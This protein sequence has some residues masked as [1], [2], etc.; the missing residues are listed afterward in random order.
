MT[1]YY[2]FGNFEKEITPSGTRELYYVNTPSGTVAVS[3]VQSGTASLYYISTDALG[4]FDVITSSAGVVVERNSFDPWGR[5]RNYS[6]WTYSNVNTSLFTGRGFTGHEHLLD[7]DLI[8]MNGRIYDPVMALF[9]SPDNFLQAPERCIGFDR[10]S[11]CFNNPLKF[12][13][14]SGNFAF[15]SFL[16][17]NALM[18]TMQWL[19]N[20]LNLGM[21]P[22]EA[23]KNTP[24]T[25]SYSG[26]FTYEERVKSDYSAYYKYS[27]SSSSS[28]SDNSYEA[29]NFLYSGLPYDLN[30]GDCCSFHSQ[31]DEELYEIEFHVYQ[32]LAMQ[33]LMNGSFENN[34]PKGK[35]KYERLAII[36]EMGIAVLP[37]SGNG[38][39]NGIDNCKPSLDAAK[40][41]GVISGNMIK[42]M[43][44]FVP[45]IGSTHTQPS[46]DQL[47]AIGNI[48][49]QY[50]NMLVKGPSYWDSL[51]LSEYGPLY[52]YDFGTPNILYEWSGIENSQG[53]KS[54]VL[55]FAP[56]FDYI[57]HIIN[58]K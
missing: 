15:W 49:K 37:G 45:I 56:N 8:N 23:F 30:G 52:V 16:A 27:S 14:P 55:N 17:G 9:I 7:F 40:R 2:A 13:D 24:M 25:L 33:S 29:Q 58:W 28:Y 3:V 36:T 38:W 26:T 1:K 11:Y 42:V 51:V 32:K 35:W 18:Y 54:R 48:E 19:N 21:T 22:G 34:D 46:C 6:D 44:K 47:V 31:E 50:C 41:A 57:S 4:S 20:V 43:G 12:T 5:R 39:S 53:F 10:Y